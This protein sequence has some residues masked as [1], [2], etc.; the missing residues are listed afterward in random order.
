MLRLLL[1]VPQRNGDAAFKPGGQVTA[2]NGLIEYL[3]IEGHTVT[4]VNI[5]PDNFVTA[6][7]LSKTFSMLKRL[8][9]INKLLGSG[10]YDYAIAFT[11][12]L[13]NLP[14]RIIFSIF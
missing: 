1:V 10:S 9:K 5:I 12:S 8:R 4:I 14:E 2:A 6:S 3:A 11:G 13:F 7:K